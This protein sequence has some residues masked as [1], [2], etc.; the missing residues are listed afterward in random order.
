MF[1]LNKTLSDPDLFDA[2]IAALTN[3]DHTTGSTF[4]GI[5]LCDSVSVQQLCL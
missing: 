3:S 1:G 5:P 4:L 2:E